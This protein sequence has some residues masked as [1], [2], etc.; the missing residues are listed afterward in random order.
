MKKVIA[1]LMSTLI[2]MM[3]PMVSFAEK[4]PTCV[5][6]KFSNDTR[7]KNIDSASVL[8]DYVLEKL[9]ASRKFNFVET[10]PID[11]DMLRLIY[12]E[13]THQL[14]NLKLGISQGNLNAIFEGAGFDPSQAESIATAEV[15]QIISPSITSKIGNDNNAE[16][17]IQ[18]TIIS[19][20]KQTWTDR[21]KEAVGD[22]A[23]LAVAAL[24]MA[25]GGN[26]G[27]KICSAGVIN[28]NKFENKNAAIIVQCDLKMIKAA[29][30]EVI[31]HEIVSG[32]CFVKAEGKGAHSAKLKYQDA[33]YDRLME[34]VASEISKYLIKALDEG[35]LFA[36]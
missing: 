36:K 11:E 5:L 3:T 6:V 24:G 31:W 27:K 18:G 14:K 34:N 17:I 28:C 19:M 25:I 9:L 2:F 13:K 22:M 32:Y 35:Q 23:V 26:G 1:I 30:G 4:R 12:D 7:F 33:M 8:S 21:R 16:Y 15:G 20:G 29:T 10:R